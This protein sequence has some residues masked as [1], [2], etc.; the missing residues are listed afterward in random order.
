MSWQ[1]LAAAYARKHGIN[2]TYFTRQMGQEAHGQDLTSPAGA[3]GPAQFMPATARSLGI[4]NVHDIH[5]AYDGAARLMA[6]YLKQYGGSWAKA[7]AAYNGGPGVVQSGH[8]PAETQNYIHTILGGGAVLPSYGVKTSLPGASVTSSTPARTHTNVDQA[9]LDTLASHVKPGSLGKTV[10]NKLAYDPTY[11]T[12]SPAH[13]TTTRIPGASTSP[14]LGGGHVAHVDGKPVAAWI[15]NILQQAKAAGWTGTVTSGY[16][17]VAEQRRI[18]NSG[19][20][21]AAKP[22][23]S[24]HNFT[25]FPG[26]AVD[27]T[28]AAQLAQVLHKLGINKLQWAGAKDPVH[29]SHPHGG[30]Y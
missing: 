19:V 16:R 20:R 18:Y 12:T 7:L 25:A 29:F 4:R 23:Q 8:L 3:Q 11:T 15:A 28:N 17:S 24:N 22:G 1:G 30:G 5:Q 27:V 13:T 21:P 6:S 2:P 26:G 14:A 9:I 10:L